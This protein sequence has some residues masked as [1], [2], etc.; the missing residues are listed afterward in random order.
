[1]RKMSCSNNI[2]KAHVKFIKVQDN[3]SGNLFL[4]L[5]IRVVV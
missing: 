1:M 3:R 2:T 4:L 5:N